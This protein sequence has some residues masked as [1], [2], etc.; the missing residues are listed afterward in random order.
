MCEWHPV[1]AG[2][3]TAPTP[4][5]YFIV[6]ESIWHEIPHLDHAVVIASG[7]KVWGG[8]HDAIDGGA[9]KGTYWVHKRTAGFV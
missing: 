6:I 1:S 2:P 7:E 5:P 8:M 3:T 9:I 4:L